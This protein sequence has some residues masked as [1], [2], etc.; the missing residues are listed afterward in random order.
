MVVV[1]V[2]VSVIDDHEGSGDHEASFCMVSGWQ[3]KRGRFDGVRCVAVGQVL[4]GF[5]GV[6][7]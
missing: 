4:G 7:V 1:V 5:W 2:V 6:G 3:T